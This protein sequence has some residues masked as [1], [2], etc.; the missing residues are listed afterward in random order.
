V[1]H[2][3]RVRDGQVRA[4]LDGPDNPFLRKPE[5]VRAE[6]TVHVDRTSRHAKITV[7]AEERLLA[8]G[9]W[10]DWVPVQ[11]PL[12]PTQA[13]DGQVRFYLKGLDPFFEL[14]ASPVNI[15]PL[16]P[17]MP[18]SHPEDY[19][20]EL[21]RANGRFY[22]QGIPEDTNARKTGVL[23]DAEFLA[24]AELAGEENRRQY[25]HVLNGFEDGLLFYYF[26]NVDQVSH[27][28]WRARDPGHPAYDAAQDGPHAEVVER[29]YQGLDGVVPA[30]RDVGPRVYDVAARVSPEQLAA[31]SR[32]PR[33][34]QSKSQGRPR[35]LRQRGLVAHARLRA[36][37]ER[38]V[39]EP[40]G[41]REGRHRR[42]G[43]T[44]RAPLRAGRAAAGDDRSQV[45]HARHH[46]GLQA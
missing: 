10:S 4:A 29:L 12:A 19:A 27:M 22:T 7:G 6:F 11:F 8:V 23:N 32:L 30:D 45:G 1:V 17:A 39:R 15:D 33:A 31:R 9:E 16:R 3:V 37:S 34:R 24:Q 5:K 35:V 26:G 20:V 28:M 44:S 25:R 2:A 40:E 38:A 18:L 36:W 14:Y 42:A 43:R 41:P 13:L 46:E 21:A